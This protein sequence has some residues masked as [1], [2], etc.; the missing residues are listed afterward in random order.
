M[1]TQE[2]GGAGAQVLKGWHGWSGGG[3]I[4][5]W[6]GWLLG[7]LLLLLLLLVHFVLL[8]LPIL[9]PDL[10][11]TFNKPPLAASSDFP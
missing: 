6:Q 8:C 2:V 3:H 9:E 10:H 7:V 4:M 11:V 5:G 1:G